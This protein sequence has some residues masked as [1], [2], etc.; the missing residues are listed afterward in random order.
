MITM[1]DMEIMKVKNRHQKDIDHEG[2]EEK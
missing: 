1:K 2:Q